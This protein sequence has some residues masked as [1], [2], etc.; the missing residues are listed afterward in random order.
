MIYI[1]S[2]HAG[3]LL[4]EKLKSKFKLHDFILHD[5]GNFEEDEKVDY[6]DFAL[7][8]CNKIKDNDFGILVCGSGQ[9]MAM[10]ANRHK[11]IRACL[12]LDTN[13]AKLARQH[14]NANV[15]CL[16]GRITDSSNAEEIVKAFLET[17]FEGGRH[18]RRLSRF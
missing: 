3:F 2:D 6:P 14:N 18:S 7:K 5:L 1:A 13:Q 9:G 12:C 17:D 4:K 11:H 16:A 10:A 8:L 15:L